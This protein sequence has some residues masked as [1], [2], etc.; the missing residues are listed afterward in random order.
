MMDHRKPKR[1]KNLLSWFT[2]D[3]PSSGSG[4]EIGS[5][6]RNV[7]DNSVN[8]VLLNSCPSS[9]VEECGNDRIET[10]VS[11]D[12]TSL[13]RDPGI[14]RPICK[15]PLNERD[16]IRRAYVVLGPFQPQL[17]SYPSSWDGGQGQKFCHKW[18]KDWHWLEYSIEL[19]KAY[20]F[21]CFLF[22]SYPSHHPAFTEYGFQGWKNVMSKQSGIL[23]HV[24]G[25]NSPHNTCMHKWDTL[26]N[27]SKH[28]ERV[29]STQSSQ[30]VANNRLRLNSTIESV[31]LLANQGCAF[32]GHDE[33]ANSSNGGNFNAVLQAF[34]RVNLEVHK[35]LHNAPGNAKYISPIIQRQILNILGNKVRTKIRE[36]VG[37]AKFCILVDEAVDVSNKEQMAIILRFVD[38]DGFIRERFFK[39][40]SVA[41][42]CS[43]TLKNE[44]SKVLAQYDL[45][46]ENMRGQGYNG[47]SN[48]RGEFNGLQALFREECPYAYYVHCFAHRL[49]LTLNAA[50]K[51]VH[52]IWQFFSTLNVIVNF[53]DS[54]A[55]RHSALRVIREEEIA[56]LVA[57]GTLETDLVTNGPNKL[58]GE[59]RSV[60]RAMKRFDFVFCLLLMHDVMKITG[61]LCQSLQKKAIDILNAL[62]FLSI[63]KSKLQ[64]MREDGWDDLIM[65]VESFCCEHDIVMPDMSTPYKKGTER[66]CEQNITKKH[67]Y[68]VNILNAVI[69]F[70]LAELDSRFTDKSLE[71]LV[72]SA[73]FDPRDNFQSFRSE[74]VCNLAL[75]FYPMDFSSSDM[76]ALD[77]KCGYFLTDIQRDPRFAKTT[78]VSNLCRRLVESRKSA[79]FPMIYRLICL[80]LTLPVSTATTERAFSAMNIIKN[81]LRNKMEDDFLDDL[82]VLNIEKEFADSI[83]NDSVIAEFEMSGPRRVRFS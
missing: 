65:R 45:Q 56:D 48:M 51:G 49:Q 4:N 24:G 39:V 3:T 61:F 30:E 37:D 64:D 63:T 19:D 34:G 12:V 77:M 78:S 66:A 41:D 70:Q 80:V 83:D 54:S 29:I 14:R 5:G 57:A 43:Q 55:K 68:R 44:I 47:A 27:P 76:L 75:K 32:R 79:F 23:G 38:C 28:I 21:P 36:E 62:N 58:Q 71:L 7:T 9:P 52:D 42:T 69:D 33:S 1:Y 26:R 59:A 8:D 22:D 53:V 15:Y 2:S 17:S 40:I 11:F 46:V 31:R 82:M 25:V 10:E 6:S 60:G 73:T 18:F 13:E 16:N 35:V 74:D 81:K 20:C 67:F 72:L 50:A